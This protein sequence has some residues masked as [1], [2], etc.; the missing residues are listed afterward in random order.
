VRAS[1][2]IGRRGRVVKLSYRVR[3]DRG[4]TA[5]SI[6][7]YRGA[8]V[9]TKLSRGLRQTDDSVAYWVAWRPR[10]RMTGRFCVRASDTAG[11]AAVSCAPLRV[12]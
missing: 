11:N 2:A 10:I 9:V 6:L 3:D 5:E 7:V 1:R 4:S 8:R 12:R